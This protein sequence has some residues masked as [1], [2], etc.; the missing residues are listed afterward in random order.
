MTRLLVIDDEVP[1]LRAMGVSL[2][3]HGY[4]VDLA[5][6]GESGLALAAE[7]RP[8][9]IVLDLGLPGTDGVE[10]LKGLR[11][12]SHVPVVVL[13]ARHSERSI[14]NALD[15]GADDYVTKPFAMGEL[16]A[17]IRAAV[18]RTRPGEDTPQ[19]D[20]EDFSVNLSEKRVVVNGAEV[21]LTP[22][23]WRLV[24]VLV[25]NRGKLVTQRQLLEEVWGSAGQRSDYLRVYMARIRR[26]LEPDPTRPRYFFTEPGM[27]CRF[28]TKRT[29]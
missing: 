10:V 27:G 3:A 17:R 8:D 26:K 25:R 15:A 18:R 22:T 19:V 20:T 13:S 23:E 14:I 6:N 7:Q 4:D 28:D 16:L 21:R 12:W 5:R 1:F 2:R 11:A 24:E 9:A 29:E